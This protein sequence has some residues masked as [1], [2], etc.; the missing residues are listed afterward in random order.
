MLRRKSLYAVLF[1]AFALFV[2]VL[3]AAAEDIPD[4]VMLISENEDA[5]FRYVHDPALNPSAMADIIADP[6]TPYGY[7]PNPDSARLGVYADYDWNDLTFII[8]SRQA[9]IEYHESMEELYALEKKLVEEGADIETVARA[10][11]GLR[12]ELRLRAY[13]GDPA[14]LEA[15]RA[16]N[17]AAYGNENG[18]T[19]DSLFEKYGSWET[20]LEK[21]FSVNSGMDACLGLY[22]DYYGLYCITG[23][24][25]DP[26]YLYN[27]RIRAVLDAF[28]ADLPDEVPSNSALCTRRQAVAFLWF[29]SLCP[30]P[31]EETQVFADVD[32][33]DLYYLPIRWAAEAGVT[34]GTG[35]GMFSPD[36]AVTRGQLAALLMRSV[37]GHAEAAECVFSDV[38]ADSFCCEAVQWAY[39]NGLTVWI[40]GDA[41]APDAACSFRETALFLSYYIDAFV[42]F[43]KEELPK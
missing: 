15:V 1:L 6:A 2:F 19:A 7:R 3:P 41:F 20:V 21:A 14:G 40:E 11:S 30:Q 9:R 22:D 28:L 25:D 43:A 18:P 27:M 4:G 34:F 5:G 33:D 42:D 23:Q 37:G 16:S 26:E 39:E 17:L 38:S 10:V 36:T 32:T 24:V 13:D 29:L 35:N 8:S 12:N 31:A